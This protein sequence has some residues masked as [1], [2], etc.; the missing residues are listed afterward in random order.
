MSA[1]AQYAASVK[2]GYGT[3]TTADTSRTA[4]TTV[5][6]IASGGQQGKRVD[7][8]N[9]CAI[10]T[11]VAS[12]VRL[13]LVRGF[14]GATILT[15]TFSATTAT[16]TTT[17]A[18]GL[19]TGAKISVEGALPFDYNVYDV[20]ITATGTTTFTY[21]MSTTPTANAVVIGAYVY[22]PTS[23]SFILLNETLVTAVTPSSTITAFSANLTTATNPATFPLLL[24][25][26][27]SLRATVNDT[28]TSSGV[29]VIAFGGAF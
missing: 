10:G 15:I 8:I 5:S 23:P 9:M 25:A 22:T 19:S 11:T 16:I 20:A 2:I 4:P 17:T 27:W 7:R 18:H 13:F 26:G 3:V 6:F 12:V 29:N 1:S 21:S 14:V 28:Q 24:E